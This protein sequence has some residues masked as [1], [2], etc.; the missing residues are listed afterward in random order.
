MSPLADPQTTED[1]RTTLAVTRLSLTDFRCYARADLDLD[2]RPVVLIGPNG[3]GKTNVLEA[4]SFLAPGRGLRMAKINEAVRKSSGSGE[5]PGSASGED[6]TRRDWAVAATLDQNGEETR[7]GTGSVDGGSRRVA[8]VNGA[9]AP[10]A[11]AFA[12]LL[13]VVWLTP[14]MD[15]L[16]IEGAS[17]RRRFL[18]RLVLGAEPGHGAAAAGYE[19]AMRTR[20]RLLAEGGGDPAWLSA[21]ESQMADHGAA[22]ILARATYL[23]DLRRAIDDWDD[24]CFPQA[25]LALEGGGGLPADGRA[26]LE[27][28]LARDLARDLA[29]DLAADLAGA[30]A[31]GRPRDRAAG[32]TLTGPHRTDFSVVHR[33]KGLPAKDCSTGEQKGLLIAIV[34]AN[35][36]LRAA[37]D[38]APPLL[39][40]D[41]VAAHLDDRRRAALFDEIDRTGAQAWMTGTDRVLFSAFGDRAQFA[42]VE[43]ARIRMLDTA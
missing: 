39:L 1:S 18:D 29:T 38:G 26:R 13:R 8:R 19:R 32:R 23:R 21:V 3:A 42:G 14:A 5:E 9:P 2:T 15:R 6:G 43:N 40:L 20:N 7:L 34:L 10:S 17:A 37:V 33:A 16:F 41:E 11:G 36:R 28:D 24:G 25:D 27:T 22:M 12:K 31:A 30:L 35:A 4:L